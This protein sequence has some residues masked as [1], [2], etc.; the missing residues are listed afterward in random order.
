[1]LSSSHIHFNL[2]KH[3]LGYVCQ[4][5]TSISI[6][7][8]SKNMDIFEKVKA[9]NANF[10]DIYTGPLSPLQITESVASQLSEIGIDNEENFLQWL[11]PNGFRLTSLHDQSVWVIRKSE[12]KSAFVHIHPSRNPPL[13]L[14]VHGNAWKTVLGLFIM[15]RND[16]LVFPNLELINNFRRN[17]LGLSPVKGESNLVRIQ[18]VYSLIKEQLK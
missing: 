16:L 1:M 3:H 18:K 11:N 15:Y 9:I 13:A 17:Y 6:E 14:R 10:V 8:G 5:L 4:V 12:Y 2:M 7:S